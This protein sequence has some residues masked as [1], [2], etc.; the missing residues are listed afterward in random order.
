VRWFWKIL[1]VLLLSTGIMAALMIILALTPAPFWTWYGL[2]TRYSGIH[3]PPDYIVLMG[4]GG[5]PSESGLIRCYYAAIAGNYFTR[6]KIIVALPGDIS[7][8][9][10]SIQ[11]MKKELV[12]RGIN[13]DRIM[14][15]D[16]GTNTRAQAINIR[17]II[18]IDDLRFPNSTSQNLTNIVNQQSSIVN[19]RSSILIVTSPEHLFR[20]VKTFKKAGFIRVDGLPAFDQAIESDI[21]FNA[22]KLGG[23]KFIPDIGENI[24]LR[25]QFW[26]QV[27]YE[28]LVIRE[29]LAIT[30]YWLNGWI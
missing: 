23:R 22:R 14:L 29:W 5:M 17:K 24:T 9:L 1:K 18:T 19:R 8:S 7:D 13:P 11:L 10:S 27:N 28:F 12:L 25:Y 2:G 26:S 15:E 16:S 30:Y 6:S 20:S 3:R 4:G 21:N